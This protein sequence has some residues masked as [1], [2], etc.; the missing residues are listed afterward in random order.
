MADT[1][2]GSAAAAREAQQNTQA[3][4]RTAEQLRATLM[5][6]GYSNE[7]QILDTFSARFAEYHRLDEEIL[8]LASESTNAKAQRLSFGPAR[9]AADAFRTSL[10][11][12]VEAAPAA[13]RV[14]V[15]ALA[16]RAMIAILDIEV[17]QAPHIAEADDATMTRME[18]RMTASEAEGRMD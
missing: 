8:Q 16:S 7:L 5:S 10:A 15:E 4:T 17:L 13:D 2:E 3:V 1:D 9:E 11:A 6:M 14:R 18:A 12:V